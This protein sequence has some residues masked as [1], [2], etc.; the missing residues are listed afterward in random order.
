M[1]AMTMK[2]NKPKSSSSHAF[3]SSLI[4]FGIHFAVSVKIISHILVPN[5]K[6]NK[7]NDINIM[8]SIFIDL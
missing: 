4:N 8:F 6:N 3:G 1:I 2:T 7:A 5:K